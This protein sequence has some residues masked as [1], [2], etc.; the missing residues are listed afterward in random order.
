MK[1][2][3]KY[4]SPDDKDLEFGSNLNYSV[5]VQMERWIEDL[6]LQIEDLQLESIRK[7]L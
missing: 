3:E 7:S 6:L 1:I 5:V 4:I 2:P